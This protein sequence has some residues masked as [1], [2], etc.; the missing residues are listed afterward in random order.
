[1]STLFFRF[2]LLLCALEKTDGGDLSPVAVCHLGYARSGTRGKH[3]VDVTVPLRLSFKLHRAMTKRRPEG[4]G[5]F[6]ISAVSKRRR[7][8]RKKK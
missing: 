8:I 4:G 2:R 5:V 1:M 3:S 6:I 7:R